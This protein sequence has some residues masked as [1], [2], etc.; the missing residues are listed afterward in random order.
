MSGGVFD[1]FDI[2]NANR[3]GDGFD[4]PLQLPA[5]IS[6]RSGIHCRGLDLIDEPA[7][8]AGNHDYAGKMRI[9]LDMAHA[10]ETIAHGGRRVTGTLA[11]DEAPVGIQEVNAG[12]H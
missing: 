8:L 3:A 6:T 5:N 9:A 12:K 11:E 2:G 7:L 1:R 10:Y 4:D